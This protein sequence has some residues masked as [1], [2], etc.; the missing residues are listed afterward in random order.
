GCSSSDPMPACSR[1][2]PSGTRWS[3]GWR[4]WPP[5]PD[6]GGRVSSRRGG[7]AKAAARLQR[8]LVVV[9]YVVKHPG[10]ALDDLA[11]MFDAERSG[12]IEDLN[13][14]FLAGLPPHGPGDLVDVELD[15]EG[16]AGL[17]LADP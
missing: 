9:P 5:M 10:T 17:G 14:L 4:R 12:L 1:P 3:L 7:S 11:R 2:G 6:R 13:L 15:E 16:R 8:L